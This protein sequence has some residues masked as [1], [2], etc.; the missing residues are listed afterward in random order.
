MPLILIRREDKA[1]VVGA[2]E[3]DGYTA[4]VMLEVT[5]DT[6]VEGT[7]VSD[8]PEGVHDLPDDPSMVSP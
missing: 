4:D 2:E 8:W 1:F 6:L 7:K 5:F 3:R